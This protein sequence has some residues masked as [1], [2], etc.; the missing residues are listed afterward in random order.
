LDYKYVVILY[1]TPT[2]HVTTRMRIVNFTVKPTNVI[3]FD[4]ERANSACGEGAYL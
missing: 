4:P 3:R 2:D 1:Q